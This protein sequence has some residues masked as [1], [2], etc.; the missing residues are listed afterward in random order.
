MTL[1]LRRRHVN[2][3]PCDFRHIG[4]RRAIVLPEGNDYD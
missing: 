1:D 4:G 2:R 3:M